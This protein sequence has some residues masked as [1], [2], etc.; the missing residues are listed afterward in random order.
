MIK[1]KLSAHMRAVEVSYGRTKL[2][3]GVDSAF[4]RWSV[5]VATSET[6]RTF[7]YDTEE[8]VAHIAAAWV[9]THIELLERKLS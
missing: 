6:W 1:M 5:T 4:G 9:D 2:A 3:V 8:Q 7:W